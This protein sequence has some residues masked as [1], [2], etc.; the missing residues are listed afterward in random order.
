M[1]FQRIPNSSGID[2]LK[3]IGETDDERTFIRQLAECGTLSSTT[4]SASTSVVFRAISLVYQPSTNANLL[5]RGKI[6]KLDFTI[7]QN[8]NFYIDL[9][10]N[11]QTLP[12]NLNT[13]SAIKLQVKISKSSGALVTL[14]LGSGL[15]VSGPDNNVLS[16]AFTPAMTQV[17][18]D[19]QYYYDLLMTK[20]NSNDYF[21]EGKINV[22]RTV[23]N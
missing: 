21:V 9:K 17:L 6:G 11:S 5:S 2:D 22:E 15:A 3:L 13:Y 10:F 14:S 18:C 16:V 4:T 20:P 12:I 19:N 1:Q 23:T 7:R 8:A